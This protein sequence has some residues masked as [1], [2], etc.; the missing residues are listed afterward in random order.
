MGGSIRAT[1]RMASRMATECMSAKMGSRE[2]ATGKTGKEL[3][4]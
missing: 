4:G 1:G 2:R 3:N